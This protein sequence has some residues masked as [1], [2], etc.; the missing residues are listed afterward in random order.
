MMRVLSLISPR[1]EHRLAGHAGFGVD[2]IQYD[3]GVHLI[4]Q[5]THGVGELM[6]W[7][8]GVGCQFLLSSRLSSCG[9]WPRHH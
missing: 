3:D 5:G 2:L 6:L 1:I 8:T 7:L 4:G 9:G